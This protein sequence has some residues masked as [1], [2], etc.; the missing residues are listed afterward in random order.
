MVFNHESL[1]SLTS[2]TNNWQRTERK[3]WK[4]GKHGETWETWDG[5]EWASVWMAIGRGEH[6]QC[7]MRM[8]ASIS[9]ALMD[10]EVKRWIVT[11]IVIQNSP[12]AGQLWNN[13]VKTCHEIA[14]YALCEMRMPPST[15]KILSLAHGWGHPTIFFFAGTKRIRTFFLP[16][17]GVL[18]GHIY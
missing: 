16:A 10:T 13:G 6:L 5:K 2:T 11:K 17:P 1:E 14:P 3:H 8:G 12:I 9:L 18:T 15:E 7:E 4:H